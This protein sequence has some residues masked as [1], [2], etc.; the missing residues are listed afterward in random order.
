MS[1]ESGSVVVSVPTVASFCASGTVEL[2]SAMSVG[3]SF[4]FVT[5]IVNCF[6]KVFA[7]SLTWTRIES[8]GCVSWSSGPVVCRS[9][10]E[11]WK[12]ALFESPVPLTRL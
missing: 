7:P 3:A 10:P 1:P 5:V 9:L 11:I 4:V 12:D 6:S 2:E 8:V